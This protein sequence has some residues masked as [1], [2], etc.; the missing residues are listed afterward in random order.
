MNTAQL[1]LN[2]FPDSPHAAELRR[3]FPDLRF[4]RE[5]EGEYVRTNLL[6]S[7]PL[8]RAAS[9][10][11]VAVV[12]G[13]MI[14]QLLANGWQR[15]T[16]PGLVLLFLII[17]AVAW[18]AYSRTYER[19]YMRRA[20]VLVPARNAL[21][22]LLAA[23]AA[24]RGE[25]EML[26]VLPI[27][28]VSPF[29]F[30]GLRLRA[31]LA[32]AI[33]TFVAF[34]F[35]AY[36]FTLDVPIALRTCAFL[37]MTLLASA[38]ACRHIERSSRTA[39]LETH[40][41]AELAEHDPLTGTKNRRVFDAHVQRLWTQAVRDQRTIAMLLVD[42]DHFKSYNDRY[43]HQAGDK[44]LREVAQVLNGFVDRPLDVL[45]RYGGEEFVA[46]LYDLDVSEAAALAER[47]RKAVE[48]LGIEH[49]ASR[50]SGRVTVSVGVAAIAPTHD[51]HAKGALQLA[52]QALYQAK[53]NGR[54]RV[55]VM[56]EADYGQLVTGVFQREQFRAAY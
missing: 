45:A 49:H 42:V 3:G 22:G 30:W 28:M 35:G 54:N 37:S 39:F 56:D 9:L 4:G 41:I 31:G 10:M 12:G 7:R 40:L 16:F 38:V 34:A 52:D 44:A 27:V 26:M 47:M 1:N 29:F 8:I 11:S 2:A 55:A 6:Q 51:R 43:G 36:W 23:A 53:I 15:P 48:A 17:I 18:A 14:E 50:S 21:I 20:L 33:G 13:R 19:T 32:S 25:Q 24:A 5:L 46:V